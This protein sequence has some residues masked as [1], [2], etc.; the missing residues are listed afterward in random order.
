MQRHLEE[1]EWHLTEGHM[2]VEHQRQIVAK[3]HA[4]GHD[5]TLAIELLNAMVLTQSEHEDR[6][7]RF[8]KELGK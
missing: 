4:G 2:M 7:D 8:L 5:T 3:L 1:T 6:R